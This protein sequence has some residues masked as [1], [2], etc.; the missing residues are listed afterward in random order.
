MN[1][2]INT[3]ERLNNI[4]LDTEQI[5]E[6]LTGTK[7][8]SKGLR[9]FINVITFGLYG[10]YLESQMMK[11]AIKIQTLVESVRD[12]NPA[13]GN[14]QRYEGLIRRMVQ[15]LENSRHT[16]SLE[17]LQRLE[18]TLRVSNPISAT[19]TREP[20]AT[21][22]L[23]PTVKLRDGISLE[24]IR[25]A[26]FPNTADGSDMEN[27]SK[28]LEQVIN[29]VWHCREGSAYK[30]FTAM[31]E[32]LRVLSELVNALQNGAETES[33][34]KVAR[35]LMITIIV[36]ERCCGYALER[37]HES[38]FLI[39]STLQGEQVQLT[40]AQWCRTFIK[41]IFFDKLVQRAEGLASYLDNIPVY[42]HEQL[43]RNKVLLNRFL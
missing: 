15:K 6:N 26:V 5:T 13:Q 21:T 9:I 33:V 41:P 11:A 39:T 42:W 35:Q 34:C 17:V 37:N 36:A 18:R 7:K 29:I 3:L 24:E 1:G 28:T 4:N 20:V 23:W 40:Y 25:Q 2:V 32:S 19:R 12:Q 38:T 30:S 14:A 22:D 43:E 31:R 10:Q 16:K 27:L 8:Y